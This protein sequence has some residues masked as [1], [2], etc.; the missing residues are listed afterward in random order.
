MSGENT[1]GI[2]FHE[3]HKGQLFCDRSAGDLINM[4]V[5]ECETVAMLRQQWARD[6]QNPGKYYAYYGSDV[7]RIKDG[8]FIDWFSTPA[9]PMG[10]KITN[11][12]R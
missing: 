5:A 10:P 9:K 2:A 7:F 6:P 3:K 11:I 12:L 4:L 1:A 8:K